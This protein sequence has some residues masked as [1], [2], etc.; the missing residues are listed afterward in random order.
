MLASR[1]GTAWP[2]APASRGWA[3]PPE[4]IEGIQSVTASL[5]HLVTRCPI[6]HR[7]PPV[8]DTS[9]GSG[10][11]YRRWREFLGQGLAD[12]HRLRNDAA[13]APPAGVSRLSAY[14]HYGCVSPLTVA[15]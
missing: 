2:E 9:G 11:G 14:L 3:E 12:Y 13:V 7:V 1:L 5:P 6:D 15:R 4:G 10:A 8:A